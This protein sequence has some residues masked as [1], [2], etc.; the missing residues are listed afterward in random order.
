MLNGAY[1]LGLMR[2]LPA[3]ELFL[4]L[5]LLMGISAWLGRIRLLAWFMLGFAA[6]W[7]AAWIV[8]DD[9]LDPAIQGETISMVV[10]VADFARAT[11]ETLRFVVEPDNRPDL[12][13]RVRLSWY[14]PETVPGLGEVWQLRVRLR[15]P[16]GYSN[17]GGFDY[18]GWLFRQRIGATGY[19][20]SHVDNQRLNSMPI[21]RMARFRQQF[22]DRVTALLPEDDAAAVLLAVAV[23]ARHRITREQWDRYAITGTSHLMAISGL[24]IGLAAAGVF[25][26]AWAIFAPFCR[27]MNVRDLALVTAVLAAGLYAA[28]SGF[29]VPARRAFLMALLA[30]AAVLYRCKLHV[31]PIIAIP[32]IVL[33]VTNPVAIHAPGFKLSF[34]AVAILFW[35]LQGHFH[36]AP[37]RAVPLATKAI[38]NLRR[39]GFLQVAL[40]TGLFPLTTLIFGRFSLIAPLMNILILPLFNFLTV[41]FCLAGM[42]LHGPL[43]ALGDQLLLVAY[44]SIRLVLSLVAFAVELPAVRADVPPLP[45]PAVLIALLPIVYVVF[46][47]GWPGRKL[48]WVAMLAILLYRPPASP[49][50]CLDYQVLDVG[51]GLAVVLRAGE[52]TVL[53]DTG[54]SFRSGTSAAELVIIPFLKS[55][56]IGK[57][58]T[59]VVSHADQDHAG[60]AETIASQFEIGTTYVGERMPG[61]GLRQISCSSA[62]SWTANGVRFQFLHPSTD[63]AWEGNNASCVLEVVTGKHKLLLTGDIET[64]VEA[65]LLANGLIGPANTVIVPHHGSRTSS[66][67]EFVTKLAP[68]LAIVSA[69]FGNRWGFPKADV[70]RRWEHAGARLLETATSGAIG[71]HICVAS[72][73]ARLSRERPESRKYWH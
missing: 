58:D 15:R 3:D 68:E 73:V 33:T 37:L 5:V 14:E 64:P 6:M 71:Q 69:G 24:H 9:R 36:Q 65:T 45:G 55:R 46:P 2:S 50:G 47:A 60:G 22:V 44:H 28:V 23:G 41:P 40:L 29:A 31:A 26:L 59:L 51:Q 61:L 38:G 48:A 20:V 57:L 12:P 70:I 42:V 66:S 16:H 25:L 56:R 34:A 43:Q 35:S 52:H 39:L 17:P 49:P 63:A 13:A 18:E 4:P 27:R 19:V 11:G 72:G 1:A 21:G 54:P 67:P 10:R 62:A 53:F 30:A 32:C 7:V 8:I